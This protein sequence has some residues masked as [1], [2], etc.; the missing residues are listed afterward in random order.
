M[1]MAEALQEQVQH[2]VRSGH[3]KFGEPT[4]DEGVAVYCR[5]SE[6]VQEIQ[7]RTADRVISMSEV[8]LRPEVDIAIGDKLVRDGVAFTVLMVGTKTDLGS[9]PAYLKVYV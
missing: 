2:L 6:Q 7:T 9:A 5:W 3:D 8:W 4:F 1:L